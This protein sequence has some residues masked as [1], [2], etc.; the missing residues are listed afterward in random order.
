MMT[1]HNRKKVE[2]AKQSEGRA[3]GSFI[4]GVYA[5]FDYNGEPIYVG[6]TKKKISTRIRRHLTN[7]H[8]DAVAMS[9]LDPFEVYEIEVWP[10]PQFQHVGKRKTPKEFPVAEQ[11]L[12]ALEG[13]V[14]KEAIAGSIGQL[15]FETTVSRLT[16]EAPV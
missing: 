12:N 8:T 7:Q 3:V 6:Q 14:H 15:G 5:F 11:H 16:P 10:L 1:N 2:V 13:L 4:W 9:V